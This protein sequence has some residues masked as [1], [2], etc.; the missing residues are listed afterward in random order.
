M[1]ESDYA[2]PSMTLEDFL[3]PEPDFSP[4]S[5]P[6]STPAQSPSP[7]RPTQAE[8]AEAWS[9]SYEE[10]RREYIEQSGR[11]QRGKKRASPPGDLSVPEWDSRKSNAAAMFFSHAW[12]AESSASFRPGRK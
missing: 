5:T 2:P 8:M 9:K 3:R 7:V 12:A 11:K 1:G 4:D 6:T 10:K